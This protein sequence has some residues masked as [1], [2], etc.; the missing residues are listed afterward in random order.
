ME[1]LKVGP[2]L[3]V[4]RHTEFARA[5]V[6]RVCSEPACPRETLLYG[7][8]KARANQIQLHGETASWN[9]QEARRFFFFLVIYLLEFWGAGQEKWK[10]CQDEMIEPKRKLNFRQISWETF[11]L[12]ALGE[13]L[14]SMRNQYESCH[15]FPKGKAAYL[16][17]L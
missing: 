17:L 14:A 9:S 13:S 6:K 1:L 11:I 3:L 12:P 16:V 4:L 5:E 2:L 7:T 8:M 10:S 15:W